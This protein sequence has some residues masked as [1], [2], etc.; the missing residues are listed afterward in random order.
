MKKIVTLFLIATVSVAFFGCAGTDTMD[1][2]TKKQNADDY[3]Q[4]G[5]QLE[6]NGELLGALEQYKLAL[7]ISPGNSE[8]T[9]QKAQLEKKIQKAAQAHYKAGRKLHRRGKY[10]LARNEFLK[11]L[12]YQPNHPG[13]L[14]MI[15]PRERIEAKRFITHIVKPEES[16][17]KI[18]II[19][20]GDYKKFPVIAQFN[21]ITDATKVTPGDEIKVPEIQGIPFLVET[22]FVETEKSK[23]VISPPA[24]DIPTEDLLKEVATELKEP[25]GELK[26]EAKME[27]EKDMEPA[28]TDASSYRDLGIELF[29]NKKYKEAIVEFKKV[30]NVHPEDKAILNYLH[31]CH[32]QPAMVLY[33]KGDYLT[34]KREFEEALKYNKD[35]DKCLTY[36]EKSELAYKESHYNKGISYFANQQLKE[37]IREWEMVADVDSEYKTVQDNIKKAKRFLKKLEEIQKSTQ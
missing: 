34:A 14:E 26:P 13:A 17:S 1:T 8:A 32:L 33:E 29:N 23:E 22:K 25:E 30:L 31:L 6:G 2:M 19:Y 11:A 16:L 4:K 24:E 28:A 12:R 27:P 18:A 35:C 21:N 10:K 15:K 3:I 20:Y 37:A 9:A 36:S 5:Q 7:T